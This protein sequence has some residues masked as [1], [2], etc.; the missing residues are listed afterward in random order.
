MLGKALCRI[1]AYKLWND[2]DPRE[3][4][5]SCCS[6]LRK[7]Y[8]PSP[9]AAGAG[10]MTLIIYLLHL[11][12]CCLQRLQWEYSYWSEFNIWHFL[13]LLLSSFSFWWKKKGC[14]I[15]VCFASLVRG[16]KHTPQILDPSEILPWSSTF[17]SNLPH[18]FLMSWIHGNLC[19]YLSTCKK[20]QSFSI[21]PPTHW[22][23]GTNVCNA[24]LLGR[25]KTN[26]TSVS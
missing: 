1:R 25:E 18:P 13:L 9:S 26:S 19:P 16:I 3:K 20:S 12:L 23:N 6:W 22:A 7:M 24:G 2:S 4:H 11:L 14:H 17:A 8:T 21:Q 15:T 10:P 5:T